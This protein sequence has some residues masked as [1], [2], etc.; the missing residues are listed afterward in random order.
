MDRISQAKI[1]E[2][3]NRLAGI[4]KG[5]IASGSDNNISGFGDMLKNQI[6]KIN[7]MKVQSADMQEK[8]VMGDPNVTLPQVMALSQKSSIYTQLL[9][10]TRNKLVASYNDIM[11]MSV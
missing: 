7:E 3:A 2:D 5:N 10:E 1:F 4:A 9:I 8:F 6:N 11:N